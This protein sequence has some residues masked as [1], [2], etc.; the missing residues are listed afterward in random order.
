M[1]DRRF[2]VYVYL[3]PSQTGWVVMYLGKG[4]GYRD[5]VHLAPKALDDG[6]YFH[7]KLKKLIRQG[8]NPQPIRILVDLTEEEAFEWEE[9]LIK[10]YGRKDLGA[11]ILYNQ[12]NGGEGISG[13]KWTGEQLRR[14]RMS[15]PKAG[16]YKG[17]SETSSGTYTAR[18]RPDKAKLLGNFDT[19]EE[20][21]R[22]YDEA[23]VKAWG[24]DCYLNFPKEWDGTK[25]LREPVEKNSF[26]LS[27]RMSGPRKGKYKG[28]FKCPNS[29]Y[30]AIITLDRGQEQLGIFDT[31]EE[32]ARAYDEAAVKAW[33]REC[34]LN[35]PEEWD[36]TECLR[37]PVKRNS[38]KLS[39]R[40]RG[41]TSKEYKGVYETPYGA[42]QAKI[43]LDGKSKYL[44]VFDTSEEA[45]HAYDRAV[46]EHWGHGW[47]N[48]PTDA[49]GEY[50][51]FWDENKVPTGLSWRH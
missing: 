30:R 17:V 42:Y 9:D 34:Y 20:A 27:I 4:Q 24:R 39:I 11:G 5:R 31:E 37:E 26:M 19:P 23:A 29:M 46:I 13:R 15:G 49:P 47:L 18:I 22:A 40:M 45:A 33:G 8:F 7:N 1:A 3:D 51:G 43:R 6:T 50:T 41:P 48:F 10:L 2:Y 16:K 44:G 35:F 38:H 25:C 28:V 14:L 32:A 36:G 12:T 21:A